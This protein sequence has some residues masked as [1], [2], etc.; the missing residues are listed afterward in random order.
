MQQT[1][2][3]QVRS[4][5]REDPLEGGTAIH[6]SIGES[7]TGE[8]QGQRSLVGYSTRGRKELDMTEGTQ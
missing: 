2:E 3:M 7:P 1:Q 5:G 6:S 8:S 4:L